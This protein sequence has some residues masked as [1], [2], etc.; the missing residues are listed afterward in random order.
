MGPVDLP[1]TKSICMLGPSGCGKKH[2]IYALAAELGAV[3]FNLSSD[4]VAKYKD[5]MPYFV[6]LV[7]KMASVLQPSVLFIDEAHKTFIKKVL[8]VSALTFIRMSHFV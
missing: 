1:K 6:H 4:V 2:I 8:F 7:T 5:D 3:V